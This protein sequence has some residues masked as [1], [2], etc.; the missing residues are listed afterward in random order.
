[1]MVDFYA[2]WCIACKEL[3]AYTFSDDKVQTALTDFV[4]LKVD[5]T[6]NDDLDKEL[7]KKFGIFGPPA[8][9]FFDQKGEELRNYRIVGFIE[10]DNFEQHIHQFSTSSSLVASNK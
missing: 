9:L 8:I 2:D 5:V 1:V 3:E 6:A 4:L 10:A 7:L